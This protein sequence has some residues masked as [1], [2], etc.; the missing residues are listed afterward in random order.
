VLVHTLFYGSFA[1]K[2]GAILGKRLTELEVEAI[3]TSLIAGHNHRNHN[4][5]TSLNSFWSDAQP[6]AGGKVLVNWGRGEGW[7]VLFALCGG[8]NLG[9][10]DGAGKV[11]GGGVWC[12]G[13]A[14]LLRPK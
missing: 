5:L 9:I 1:E 3:C 4:M 6:A 11:A 13:Y 10:F 2:E 12:A 14:V 8:G 7:A